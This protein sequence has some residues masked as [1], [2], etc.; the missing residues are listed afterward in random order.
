MFVVACRKFMEILLRG[1]NKH[2]KIQKV[3]KYLKSLTSIMPRL[4]YQ[5]NLKSYL[6]LIAFA[7]YIAYIFVTK[8]KASFNHFGTSYTS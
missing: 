4:F 5:R 6:I 2:R 8:I 7:I 1:A 3:Y